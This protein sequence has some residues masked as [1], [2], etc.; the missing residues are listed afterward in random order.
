MDEVNVTTYDELE[1]E[2]SRV[3]QS[4]SQMEP[5]SKEFDSLEKYLNDLYSQWNAYSRSQNEYYKNENDFQI[6]MEEIEKEKR[7]EK[8][9]K[10]KDY[11]EI[12]MG[13]VSTITKIVL[14]M[15][16][17]AAIADIEKEGTCRSKIWTLISKMA[18]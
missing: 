10:I 5:G 4:I 8:H 1:F 12:G 9:N 6:R 17:I 13:T 16:L 3:K 14:P 11:C 15:V 2:I 7:E 18:V